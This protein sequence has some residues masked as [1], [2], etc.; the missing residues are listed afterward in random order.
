VVQPADRGGKR[1]PV[2]KDPQKPDP[3]KKKP[4]KP[5]PE[6]AAGAYLQAVCAVT[7]GSLECLRTDPPGDKAVVIKA[8]DLGAL[9][10]DMQKCDVVP[11]ADRETS[12]KTISTLLG[13]VAAPFDVR[14]VGV[15]LYVYSTDAT[16][17]PTEVTLLETIENQM[18]AVLAASTGFHMELNLPNAGTLT[19]IGQ[20]LQAAAPAGL[21]VTSKGAGS[22]RIVSDGSVSCAA[23]KAFLDDVYRFAHHAKPD[24]P[25]AS[26]FYLDPAAAG[27]A[28]GGKA[29]PYAAGGAA[30]LAGSLMSSPKADS[31]SGKG[32]GGGG[33]SSGGDD[34]SG[35]GDAAGGASGGKS[36]GK[37]SSSGPKDMAAT[38]ATQAV[39]GISATGGAAASTKSKSPDAPPTGTA[40]S[41]KGPVDSSADSSGSRESADGPPDQRAPAAPAA[42]SAFSVNGRDLYFSGGTAGDDAWITEKKRALALLDLPQP[43]VLVNAWVMQ[44]STTKAE[45]SGQLTNLL[46]NVVNS[47]NDTIQVSLYLGW[48]ELRESSRSGSFF[49]DG[50]YQYITARTIFDPRPSG[51]G[52]TLADALLRGTAGKRTGT[53]SPVKVDGVCPED[54]YCLG[55]ATLFKPTEPRLTDMLLTL[56]AAKNP[57]NEADKSIDAIECGPNALLGQSQST[58]GS[59]PKSPCAGEDKHCNR[60]GNAK[61]LDKVLL[62]QKGGWS[63]GG[64]QELDTQ[65]LLSRAHGQPADQ[66]LPLEC[67]RMVMHMMG[68]NDSASGSQIKF[69]RAAL[70]DF[71]FNY[72]LSQEYPHEFAA[73]DLTASAQAL[74]AALAPFIH[75]FNEDLQAFQ[76]YVRAQLM[77]GSSSMK[78]AGDKNTFLND[79][80]ITVQ[81]TSGDVASVSTGA[82]S[83]LNV[84]KAPSISQ[85][86]GGM[87]GSK[88]GGKSS[89][90]LSDLPTSDAQVL[91]GALSAYQTTSMNVGRQLNLVVKPRSLLGA[92]AAEMDVQLNADQAANAPN[93]W[94]ASSGGGAAA[95]LS[96]VTQHDTTTHV[97]IDS[98]RLFDISSFTAILSKGRDKFP[99]LPPFVE[100][101]Y[102]GTLLGIPLQ[103]AREFHTSNAV[104]SAVIVPTATDIAYSLRFTS[105]RVAVGHMGDAL[106]CAWPPEAGSHSCKVRRATALADFGGAPIREFHRERLRCILAAGEDANVTGVI[107]NNCGNLTFGNILHEDSE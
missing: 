104:V 94:S 40:E 14:P 102:V 36:G 24:T 13:S 53:S 92:S 8:P 10:T 58:C 78:L 89:G 103:A 34:G 95:D 45:N 81:T 84:S 75:A 60:G 85:L 30:A 107:G 27:A 52:N 29:I 71:L 38:N 39:T 49:D 80:I 21:T 62:T 20:S 44:S 16:L 9:P 99:V 61:E 51:D 106:G 37:G 4:E 19:N 67:F 1:Q 65:K 35:G 63:S 3:A 64:C 2:K 12:A 23:L 73:Y 74:D 69:V 93:Y 86:L 72:K 97:R 7:S 54:Q 82:Q 42:D 48:S 43:Q 6:P 26:V 46:H 18:G 41:D 33:K 77:V 87:T 66:R 98:I 22:V 68:S 76:G 55:Y 47:F 105:D 11:D 50:F 15:Y 101:P 90:L 70:A 28:I 91:M 79:G 17:K 5:K 59:E 25:V 31:G 32:D 96:Q 83:F 57:A 56:I 88:A 100:I